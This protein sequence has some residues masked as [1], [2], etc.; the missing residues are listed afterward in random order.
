MPGKNIR[1]LPPSL[2]G[3]TNTESLSTVLPYDTDDRAIEKGL[4]THRARIFEGSS[5]ML[6]AKKRKAD[7]LRIG[8]HIR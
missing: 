5:D 8:S 3:A 7:P 6:E 2:S 1:P 4:F